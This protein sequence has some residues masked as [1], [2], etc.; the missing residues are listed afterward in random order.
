MSRI[1]KEDFLFD[2]ESTSRLGMT[3]QHASLLIVHVLSVDWRRKRMR[4]Q[5]QY[6]LIRNIGYEMNH[7][8]DIAGNR[9]S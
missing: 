4:G 3:I 9:T 8:R 5:H 6:K 7:I 1:L 2:E